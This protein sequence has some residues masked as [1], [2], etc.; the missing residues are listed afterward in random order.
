MYNST[1]VGNLRKDKFNDIWFSKKMNNHRAW[2]SHCKGCWAGC[3]SN[4]NAIYTGD[5]WRGI[6]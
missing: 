5:I 1:V 4:V 3:E 6:F 2:V